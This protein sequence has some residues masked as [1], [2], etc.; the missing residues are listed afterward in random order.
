MSKTKLTED[1]VEKME[2][3]TA[4]FRRQQA[5]ERQKQARDQALAD[6]ERL[7]P[8]IDFVFGDQFSAFVKGAESIA[9]DFKADD[10]ST[11]L[12]GAL[13]SL[14]VVRQQVESRMETVRGLTAERA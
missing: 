12:R 14:G 11:H 13:V 10:L 7:K 2:K 9:S 5:E 1:Q 6:A 4:E 3:E 8:L